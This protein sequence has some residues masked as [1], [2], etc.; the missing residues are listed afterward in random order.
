MK[1]KDVDELVFKYLKDEFAKLKSKNTLDV[2]LVHDGRWWHSSPKHWNFSAASKA[3]Q[4]VFGVKP[5]LTRE[6][7]R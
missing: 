5:D 2:S 4:D 1:G 6:G 3:V 7:G